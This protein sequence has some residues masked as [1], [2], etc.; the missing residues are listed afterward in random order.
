LLKNDWKTSN[1]KNVENRDLIE[2]LLNLIENK[3]GKVTWTHVEG[4]KG[5]YGNEQADEL[6]VKG[7]SM[8]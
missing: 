1:N 2:K 3:K 7:S 5:H 8:E 4:H 6:A